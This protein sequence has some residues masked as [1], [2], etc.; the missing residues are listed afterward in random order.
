M[1]K[2]IKKTITPK[3]KVIE[4]GFPFFLRAADRKTYT[5][6]LHRQLDNERLFQ[7]SREINW[8][9]A[10]D[11]KPSMLYTP[12]TDLGVMALTNLGA[13]AHYGRQGLL[14]PLENL[15]PKY[16]YTFLDVGWRKGV[17]NDRLYSVP[18]H[19]SIRLLFYRKDLLKK[20]FF[21]P[22]QIWEEVSEQAS[23]ILKGEK[24][25]SLNG[26]L[27][28]FNPPIRFS[29]FL[30]YL[31]SQGVDLYENGPDWT[32]NRKALE[33]ALKLLEGFFKKGLIP[34]SV[35]TSD[36]TDAYHQFLEGRAVFMHHWSD[37]I[38]MIQKLPPEQRELFGWCSLPAYS[39]KVPGK[40]IVGGLNYVIPKNTMYPE[41]ASKALERIMEERFQNWYAEYLGSPYPGMKSVYLDS[42]V[43][44]AHPYLDQAEYFLRHGKLLEECGYFQGDYLD[45]LS[46]GGQELTFFLEG[47]CSASETVKRMEE[48]FAQLLPQSLYSGLTAKA[49]GYIQNHLETSLKVEKIAEALKISPEH[50]IRVFKQN[51][52]QTPLQYI[53]DAKM[54]R[55]KTLLKKSNLSVGEIA[56]QLGYKNRDH[57]SRLFHKLVKRTPI[58]YRK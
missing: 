6:A 48:R 12:Q 21:K 55:A 30:D 38:Q 49:V 3:T 10:A 19:V 39:L 52:K 41:A 36:Y 16:Q 17:I 27:M 51:T 54:E 7:G 33:T 8:R 26:L 42:A 40:S 57:F 11:T 50:F 24:T 1:P 35:Q 14:M 56:Y 15:F 5:K 47:Q 31:W 53:N 29:V 34:K 32:L 22:P 45:W 37:G 13:A 20:Y 2:K 4:L 9:P 58:E 44:K 43:R 46:I 25:E 23:V 18:Q 28:N